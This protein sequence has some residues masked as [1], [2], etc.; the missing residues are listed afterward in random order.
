MRDLHSYPTRQ[1][2]EFIAGLRFADLPT[3]VV[4]K[5][6]ELF[7][8]W[9]ASALAGKGSRPVRAFEAFAKQMGPVSI[10][11]EPLDSARDR[12]SE[13]KSRGNLPSGAS[14]L[15]PSRSVTSPYFAALING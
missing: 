6:K 2:S 1:L 11:P 5:A 7:L 12:R 3:A 8:D 10:H 15:L 13:A 14:E 4:E 9:F